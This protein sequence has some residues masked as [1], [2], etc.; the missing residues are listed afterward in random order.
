MIVISA[1]VF[2]RSQTVASRS[3]R[4]PSRHIAKRIRVCP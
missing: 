1:G 2:V 4:R 3:G